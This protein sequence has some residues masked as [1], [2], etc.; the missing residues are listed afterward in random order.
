[1]SLSRLGF[2]G[3]GVQCIHD[4]FEA[5]ILI[6][7]AGAFP[8][9]WSKNA[10]S[11]MLALETANVAFAKNLIDRQVL[12]HQSVAL[13][14][15]HFRNTHDPAGTVTQTLDLNHNINGTDNHVAY[16]ADR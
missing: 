2:V 15:Q 13:E 7:V 8:H 11:H 3:F 10:G 4:V 1:M 14:P 5:C 9:A 12:H 16:H 6:E